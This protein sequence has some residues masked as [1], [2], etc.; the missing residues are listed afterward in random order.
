[1]SYAPR[2]FELSVGVVEFLVIICYKLCLITQ[3]MLGRVKFK[4]DQSF[5]ISKYTQFAYDI[6]GECGGLGT[7][8]CQQD[9]WSLV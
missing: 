2:N 8:I 7:W 9:L 5:E 6:R 1:M 3:A 4:W